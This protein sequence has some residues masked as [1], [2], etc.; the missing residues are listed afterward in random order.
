VTALI[1]RKNGA[2][3][4]REKLIAFAEAEGIPL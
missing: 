3:S 1:E 2:G 4:V